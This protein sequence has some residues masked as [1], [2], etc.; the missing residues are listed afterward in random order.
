[1][2]VEAQSPAVDV[3]VRGIELSYDASNERLQ[4]IA[5]RLE[6]IE[7]DLLTWIDSLPSGAVLYDIGASNGPFAMYAAARGLH[8]VAFEPEAQNYASLERTH[9]LNRSRIA[10]P[11]IVLN[12]AVADDL[13][14]GQLFIQRYA[15]GAH[16]KILDRPVRVM[17]ED[18]FEPAH[19]QSVLTA[20]LDWLVETL[21]LPR[22]EY[23]KID[24]DGAEELVLSG[25][26]NTLDDPGLSGIF[27]EIA[28]PD[29]EGL[30]LVQTLESHGF[31]LDRREQ[32]EHYEGLYNCVFVRS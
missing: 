18:T 19:V 9:F 14:V 30:S 4:S 24:V 1:M 27:V 23:L 11:M 16:V 8:V 22:P 10:H 28:R 31:R 21:A 29:D 2:T 7:P 3:I 25:A 26:T 5:T 15:A 12:L 32:V 17:E 13:R 20:P 6:E